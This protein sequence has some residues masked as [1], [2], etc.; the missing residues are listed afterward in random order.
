MP[1]AHEHE[2]HRRRRGLNRGLGLVLGGFVVLVFLLTFVKITNQNMQ[3]PDDLPGTG[4][5]GAPASGTSGASAT[6][7]EEG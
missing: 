6:T 3:F 5:A 1:L 2:L 7:G 4:A